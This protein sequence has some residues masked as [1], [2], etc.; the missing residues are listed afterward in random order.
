MKEFKSV[1]ML[2]FV[3]RFPTDVS[4]L[5]YLSSFKWSD[6]FNCYK[7]GGVKY[8]IR[9]GTQSRE[10]HQCH[11][12]ESPTAHTLFHGNRFGLRKAF[13]IAFEMSISSKSISA[14]QVS[15]RYSISYKTASFYM[16]KVRLAVKSSE[17]FP[18]KSKVQVD[19]F[20]FGGKENLKQGRSN[21]SK[22]KKLI[23]AVELSDSEKVKRVYFQKIKNYSAKSL[24]CIFDLHISK[25]AE[26]ETDMW[27]GYK[28]IAK[29]YNITQKYSDKGRG[30][31]QMH[32]I[33]HQVKSWMRCIYSWIHEEHIEKYLAEYS[34]RINRS[35]N[36]DSCF[37]KLIFRMIEHQEVN[38][39]TI[40]ISN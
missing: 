16:Q 19:E 6:N 31:K 36:K 8:T 4:C 39:Q 12:I 3:D 15:S 22:K 28:P 9:K 25:E 40:I 35:Q 20:V 1:E 26:V 38:Y 23:G 29:D 30:M 27:T 7:C 21:D 17:L 13:F 32:I 34:F 18:M 10:C 5:K 2:E 33:I 24:R 11:H 37:H 14:L